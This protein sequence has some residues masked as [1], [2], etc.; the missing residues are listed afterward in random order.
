M[1]HKFQFQQLHDRVLSDSDFRILLVSRPEEALRLINIEPTE[2]ILKVLKA[3]IADVQ[4]L[5]SIFG[6]DDCFFAP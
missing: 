4:K 5:E 6:H 1:E 2:D 3:V